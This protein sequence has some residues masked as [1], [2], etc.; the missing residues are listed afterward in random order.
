MDKKSLNALQSKANKDGD[1]CKTDLTK[2]KAQKGNPGNLTKNRSPSKLAPNNT[3]TSLLIR[4]RRRRSQRSPPHASIKKGR[5]KRRLWPWLS[6]TGIT[7]RLSQRR[8]GETDAPA[9]ARRIVQRG[10]EVF[11]RSYVL[12]PLRPRRF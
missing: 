7:R 2:K 12:F 11:Q 6:C 8:I 5:S 9:F 10:D 1:E 4:I 3:I